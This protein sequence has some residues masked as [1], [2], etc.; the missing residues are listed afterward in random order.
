MGTCEAKREGVDDVWMVCDNYK[1]PVHET[2]F[3]QTDGERRYGMRLRTAVR[4]FGRSSYVSRDGGVVGESDD[5][6]TVCKMKGDHYRD[7]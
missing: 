3:R 5:H 4:I 1:Y 2:P 6:K 7:V